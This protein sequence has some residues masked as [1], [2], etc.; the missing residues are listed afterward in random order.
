MHV[1]EDII[2]DPGFPNSGPILY[3]L[4]Y[5]CA[6]LKP[7]FFAAQRPLF[8]IYVQIKCRSIRYVVRFSSLPS[9]SSFLPALQASPGLQAGSSRRPASRPAGHRFHQHVRRKS[10]QIRHLSWILIGREALRTDCYYGN[11]SDLTSS[12]SCHIHVY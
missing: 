11:M 9:V 7:P 10:C 3:L 5:V 6:A 2:I 8:S 4:I 1:L 12:Q